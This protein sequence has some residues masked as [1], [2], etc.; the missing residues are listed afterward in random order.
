MI[1][2]GNNYYTSTVIKI[3]LNL[4][5]ATKDTVSLKIL[6]MYFEMYETK[7]FLKLKI[8]LSKSTT[9]I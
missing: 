5:F 8:I 7:I 4:L 6:F 2:N 9:E 3:L 1:T